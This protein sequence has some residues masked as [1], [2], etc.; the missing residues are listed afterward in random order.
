MGSLARTQGDLDTGRVHLSAALELRRELGQKRPIL[1]STMALGLL[2][3]SGADVARGRELI[4]EALARAESVDDL[5]AM[6][7]VQTNWGLAEER[8][9]DL[10]SAERLL[11]A[12]TA[13]WGVQLMRRFEG[14]AQIALCDVRERLDDAAG[15]QQALE[16]ARELLLDSEDM[17]AERYLAT[18][19][20][21]SECKDAGS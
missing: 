13:L 3:M 4:G 6:A 9:G 2:E 15:A 12:G 7:G 10:E 18:K 17:E 16:A 20:P 11:D 21:L 8:R 1:M 19:A 5:P 14:W